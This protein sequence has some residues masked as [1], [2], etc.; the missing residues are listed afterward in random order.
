M[1]NVL[2]A[3]VPKLKEQA[4]IAALVQKVDT[5]RSPIT[6]RK[7]FRSARTEEVTATDPLL[8]PT[9]PTPKRK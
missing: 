9:T 1:L 3:R 4:A 2:G 7:N 5:G 8:A 6:T